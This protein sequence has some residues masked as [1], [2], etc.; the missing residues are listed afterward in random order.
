MPSVT[1]YA[2]AISF[3]YQYRKDVHLVLYYRISVI[4]FGV[5]CPLEEN[6]IRAEYSVMADIVGNSVYQA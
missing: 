6:C 1:P 2:Y 4:F 5:K 3:A